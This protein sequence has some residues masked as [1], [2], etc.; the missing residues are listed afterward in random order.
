[1]SISVYTSKEYA[2]VGPYESLQAAM[3]DLLQNYFLVVLDEHQ[4]FL[5]I[6]TIADVLKKPKKI[7]IDCLS[8]K[9][10]VHSTEEIDSVL[11]KFVANRTFVLPFYVG[12]VFSG[13]ITKDIIFK[14]FKDSI[15]DLANKCQVSLN[16]K[17]LFLN[18]LSHEIRTPLNGILGFMEIIAEMDEKELKS[19]A[20][21]NNL[22]SA[23][24]QFLAVMNDIVDLSLLSTGENLKLTNKDIN[25]VEL[26][27]D[28]IKKVRLYTHGIN[29][30][31][32]IHYL[33]NTFDLQLVADEK[34]LKRIVFHLVSNAIKFAVG[35]S[36]KCG[37][38]KCTHDDSHIVIFIKNNI[39]QN[40][41]TD[42]KVLYNIFEKQETIGEELN[43]GLGIG[44]P[45]VKHY[46]KLMGGSFE[47]V[48][49]GLQIVANLELPKRPREV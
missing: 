14:V 25:L 7:V 5:G 10:F 48:S 21:R 31:L 4:S 34:K 46:A 27:E 9:D 26:F 45:L 44:L 41:E 36:I 47:L 24:D 35:G 19:F 6:L 38:E 30:S 23:A 2:T 39:A 11:Q 18:N 16:A 43:P 3:D 13:V 8:K 42:M 20:H 32:N 40:T 1:M 22:R 49:D 28:T 29:S 15:T 12:E 17:T 33:Q 37:I